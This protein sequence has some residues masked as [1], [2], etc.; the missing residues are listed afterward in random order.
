MAYNSGYAPAV[1]ATEIATALAHLSA[2]ELTAILVARH[3]EHLVQPTLNAALIVSTVAAQ[4][5]YAASIAQALRE[6]SLREL[7]VLRVLWRSGLSVST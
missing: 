5:S 1:T 2:D 7:T 6:L 4:L 3:I